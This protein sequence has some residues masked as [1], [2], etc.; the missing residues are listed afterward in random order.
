VTPIPVLQQGPD[1][2]PAAA[3]DT[4]ALAQASVDS[5]DAGLLVE[6]ALRDP[7][8]LQ[9]IHAARRV[10]LLAVGKAAAP[11]LAAARRVMPRI[12]P[13]T[14]VLVTLSPAEDP[15]DTT[16]KVLVSSHPLP[17]AASRNASR[18]IQRH[19]AAAGLGPADLVITLISGGTSSM[20]ADP[21]PPMRVADLRRL[22]RRFL[23]SGLDVT[24][25]NLVRALASPLL[26][27]GLAAL[28]QPASLL[29][30]ILCDNVQTGVVAVGSGPTFPPQAS[31]A[32]A[33]SVA[34]QALD[35]PG[36]RDRLRQ[37][38]HGR[39]APL[40]D[41]TRICNVK[42]GS[43]ADLV[44][45]ACEHAHRL[46]Y[47]TVVVSPAVQGEARDVAQMLGGAIRYH[48]ARGGRI[49]LVGAGE[50]VVTVRGRGTGGRCQELAWAMAGQ[51]AG[52]SGVAFAAMASDGRDYVDGVGGAWCDGNTRSRLLDAGYDLDRCLLRND[53]YPGL[54]AAGRLLPGSRSQTNLADLYVACIDL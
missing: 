31:P 36:L 8:L 43:P 21:L 11:M 51:L 32:A 40:Q 9:R 38:L 16:T 30:L 54:A 33:T 49:C 12:E 53:T 6:R 29:S 15:S 42:I 4:L 1:D 34:Y 10:H 44:D 22:S 25:I 48:A 41:W 47:R 35:D 45:A 39:P 23:A 7:E 14:S 2:V 46:G 28:I 18:A 13:A 5:V 17:S 27:G 52:M 24:R 26:G 19:L 37:A 50:V 3:V 20:L